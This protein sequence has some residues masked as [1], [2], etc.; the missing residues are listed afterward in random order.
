MNKKAFT[1][2]TTISD[3]PKRRP[4][5]SKI[6]IILPEGLEYRFDGETCLLLDVPY[7]VRIKPAKETTNGKNA[8]KLTA[9][10]SNA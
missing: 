6:S 7:L 3:S 1:E 4:Y 9:R 5:V 8:Q 10:C 2:I